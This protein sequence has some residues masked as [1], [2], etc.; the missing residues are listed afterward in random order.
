M[1]PA[2]AYIRVSTERQAG[3]ER[4]SLADQRA[5]IEQR[6]QRLGAGVTTWYV[7]AGASGATAEGRPQFLALLAH[8]QSNPQPATR[9]GLVLALNNSRWGRFTDPEESAYWRHHL[10]RHGWIVRFAEGDEAEDKTARSVLRAIG[11]AQSTQYR[12]NLST[13]SRRGKKGSAELGYWNT[14]APFGYRRMVVFPLGAERLLESHQH[15]APSEKVRLT[16]HPDEAAVVRWAFELY[17]GGACS[18]GH[19]VSELRRRA[20]RVNWSRTVVRAMLSNP[21]YCGDVV[22]GRR[23]DVARSEQ[24]TYG[25]R[26][27]HEAVVPRELWNAVQ[28]RLSRNRSLGRAV[29]TSYLLTGLVTCPHCGRH[30]CGGGGGRSRDAQPVREFRRFYRDTGGV[31]GVCPGRIGTIMR[32]ILDG[33]LIDTLART[34]GSPAVQRQITQ[35]L[36]EAL[37]ASPEAVTRSESNLRAARQ[38]AIT[39]RDRLIAAIADGTVL[40]DEAVVQLEVLRA[41]VADCDAQLEALRFRGRRTRSMSAERDRLLQ[42]V[43]EFPS[44]L[45]RL[46]PARQRQHVEPWLHSA[47]FDKVTRDL[48]VSIRPLPSLHLA[49]WPAPD[50]Q[51]QVRPIVRRVSLIS[52]RVQRQQRRRA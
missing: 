7:D 12:E 50:A 8:C 24:A 33:A 6:A 18:T 26:D 29:A 49:A 4:T 32:H 13:N 31:E 41:D 20:L 27:A 14:R 38:R 16:P 23:R 36:D 1:T 37:S 5:S 34:I 42:A 17:A 45:Q 19:L 9:P 25:K 22:G 10:R 28:Q 15:K 48:S 40:H 35:A 51:K 39:R 43:L 21:A 11:D 30:Y 52:E 44:T 2:I 3:E 47:T 46:D